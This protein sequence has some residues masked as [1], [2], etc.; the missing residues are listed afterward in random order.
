M[1]IAEEELPHVFKRFHRVSGTRARTQEGAGIGSALVRRHDG[2][3]RAAGT[4]EQGTTFR[5]GSRGTHD[6][7][8]F[9]VFLFGAGLISNVFVAA[10]GFRPST[11]GSLRSHP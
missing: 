2:R 11:A 8:T 7:A 5:S 9:R 6:V 10:S 4:L 1:G 3:V